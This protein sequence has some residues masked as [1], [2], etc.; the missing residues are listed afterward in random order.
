[1]SLEENEI[2]FFGMATC[3]IIGEQMVSILTRVDE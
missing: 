2:V 1:M 3:G